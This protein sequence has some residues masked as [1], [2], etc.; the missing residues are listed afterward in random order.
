MKKTIN[1]GGKDFLMECNALLPRIYRKEFGRDVMTEM[2]KMS[3][4]SQK[5][6]EDIDTEVLENI[7]W[8][9]LKAAGNDVG[10]SVDEWLA[11]L[12][13]VMAVYMVM[14]EVIDLWVNSQ[15]TTSKPK[16]K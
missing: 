7:T 2:R 8:L 10:E 3:E 13:D 11:T 5:D 14:P 4:R 12:D 16:K 15:K 1:I 6:P 9:M